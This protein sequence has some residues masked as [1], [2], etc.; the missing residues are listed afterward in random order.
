MNGIAPVT[1]AREMLDIVVSWMAIAGG[2]VYAQVRH[3]YR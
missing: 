3:N 2:N 1:A